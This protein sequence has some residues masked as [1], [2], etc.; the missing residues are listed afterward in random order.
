LREVVREAGL[1][2]DIVR[3]EAMEK[4]VVP[5]GGIRRMDKADLSITR[6]IKMD[7]LP[8]WADHVRGRGRGRGIRG[9]QPRGGGSDRGVRGGGQRGRG[10]RGVERS[11]GRGLRGAR[12]R[13][14]GHSD[15][16]EMTG[17]NAEAVPDRK[18]K[19]K[20]DDLMTD[21]AKK[22]KLS[23]LTSTSALTSEP[24][25]ST[26]GTQKK[27]KSLLGKLLTETVDAGKGFGLFD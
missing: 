24:R 27:K 23:A 18:G 10:G 1:A 6:S 20:N 9:F 5:G 8:A 21:E 2:E 26:S 12:G 13:G 4:G 22:V 16:L 11:R 15:D 19:R 7:S 17:G 25:A 3:D 14:R